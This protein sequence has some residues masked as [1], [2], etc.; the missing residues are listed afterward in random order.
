[1]LRLEIVL[2][3]VY[4]EDTSEFT[5]STAT[6]ELEHS[7][8]SMSKWESKHEKPFLDD[9]EKSGSELMDYI[10]LMTLTPEVPEEVYSKLST[11]NLTAINDYIASKQTATWFSEEQSN[12]KSPRQETITSELVYYW[13]ISYQIPMECQHWHLNRL[14]TLIRVFNIKSQKPKKMSAA[15]IAARNRK[16]NDE[17]RRKLNTRG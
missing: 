11:A 17:R 3:E 8:S 10:R 1:M 6:I 4:D 15:E 7:L 5:S 14:F 13:M 12:N 2:E 16:L 9:S